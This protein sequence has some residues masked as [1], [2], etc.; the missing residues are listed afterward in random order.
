MAFHPGKGE[1]PMDWGVA[2]I[3]LGLAVL[4]TLISVGLRL[5]VALT[6]ILVGVA[7]GALLGKDLLQTNASW[8]AFLAGVG[9]VLLTF[10]AGEV[11]TPMVRASQVPKKARRT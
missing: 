9:S 3:W 8:V 1:R 6:E 2:A 7:A 11:S 4:P 10:L 5:S